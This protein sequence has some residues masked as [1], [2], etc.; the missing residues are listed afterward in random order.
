MAAVALAVALAPRGSETGRWSE[1]Q[2]TGR[3]PKNPESGRPLT[4]H[5]GQ[6]LHILR[7]HLRSYFK[8]RTGNIAAGPGEAGDKSI[9]HRIERVH[10]D[11]RN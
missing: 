10:H 5:E 9:A 1:W 7:I 11:A 3:V 4:E 6:Q 8:R 2:M